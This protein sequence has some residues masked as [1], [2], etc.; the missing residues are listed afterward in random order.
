MKKIYSIVLNDSVVIFDKLANFKIS[1][2]LGAEISG[3][4][5]T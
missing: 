4:S 2:G 1:A 3:I 5:G